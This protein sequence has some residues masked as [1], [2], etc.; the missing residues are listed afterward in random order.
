MA[1]PET[2]IL[3]VSST[4]TITTMQLASDPARS[5]M[6]YIL[7]GSRIAGPFG[8]PLARHPGARSWRPT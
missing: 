2:G 1:D 8:L 5:N 4:S 6:R 7:A 3:Y